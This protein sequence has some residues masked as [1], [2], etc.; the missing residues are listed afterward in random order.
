[1]S[2]RNPAIAMA[3]A[4]CAIVATAQESGAD[5]DVRTVLTTRLGFNNGE[6]SELSRG[7][8]VKHGLQSRAPGEIAVA[9]AVRI[10]ASKSAFFARVR[11]IERFK[12]GEG[13]LQIGRFSS[14]PVLEDLAT[15]TIDKDDFDPRSCRVGDCGV[16]LPASAIERIPREIDLNAPDAQARGAAF[17]KQILLDD[18]SAYLSGTG[19]MTQYDDGPKP[20][21]PGDELEGI[22]AAMPEIGSLLPGLPDHLRHFPTAKLPE[23]EDFLYWSKE[24]FG[25]APFITVTHVTIVCRSS[26]TCLMTTRDVYS[27]RYLDASV[28]LAIASDAGPDAFDL[29]Y[30]NRSRASAL[31]GGFASVRRMVT[32]RRARGALEE[33]L[34]TIKK[35]L[36]S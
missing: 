24:K 18:V 13:V 25:I 9:G 36:E 23:A 21:R 29:V 31:K 2:P 22:L 14:P 12:S 11:D 15:L 8:T 5:H 7:Q 35:L 26:A 27:S 19:R 33:S 28:A 30:D 3:I 34:K 32:E 4:C 20:I 6:L 16:R 1:M 17:L 10:R